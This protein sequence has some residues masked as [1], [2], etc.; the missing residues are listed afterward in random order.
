MSCINHLCQ[1]LISCQCGHCVSKYRA[2]AEHRRAMRAKAD[3]ATAHI[4]NDLHEHLLT[5]DTVFLENLEK[6]ELK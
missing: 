5:K 4:S 1:C 6:Q 3:V 2:R